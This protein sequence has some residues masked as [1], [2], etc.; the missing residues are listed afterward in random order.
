MDRLKDRTDPLQTATSIEHYEYDNAGRIS[1]FTDRRGS[2]TRYQYDNTG[3]RNFIGFDWSEGVTHLLLRKEGSTRPRLRERWDGTQQSRINHDL[4]GVNMSRAKWTRRLALMLLVFLS[5]GC[6][7][8]AANAADQQRAA[9]AMF[10]LFEAIFYVKSDLLSCPGGYK[11]LPQQDTNTLRAP[12]AYLLQGL[13]ALGK[14]AS[15]EM[16]SSSDAALVGAKNFRPPAGSTGLG[17]VQSQFCYVIVLGA[18]STFD[19]SKVASKSGVMSS[20]EG[21]AWKWSAK[22]TEGHPEPHVFFASQGAHS[23]VLISNNLDGLHAMAAKLSAIDTAP[24]M[25]SIRDWESISQHEEWGYRVY[26]HI[27]ADSK[28]AAGT[29]DVTPDVQALAFFVHF[30][31]KAGVLR[32]FSPTAGTADKMNAAR[33][34]SPFKAAGTGA[35]ETIIPLTGDR[36]SSDQL[37]VAMSWFGFGVYL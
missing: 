23:Y 18:R 7:K 31:Q 10:D 19:L 33:L 8:H 28:D 2:V 11:G 4:R 35:W 34:L 27:E 20:A 32:L 12:F 30:K 26:R 9:S 13:D 29:V 3:R 22:G 21:T 16:L 36:K 1:K 17:D 25:S 37:F 24:T 5:S 15:Q 14:S 6:T